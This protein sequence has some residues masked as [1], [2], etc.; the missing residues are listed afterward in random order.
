M[1]LR[2]HCGV[3]IA[4]MTDT[5][6][7]CLEQASSLISASRGCLF[8]LR[9]RFFVKRILDGQAWS[10][11]NQTAEPLAPGLGS[12]AEEIRPNLRSGS[13]SS[14]SVIARCLALELK[15]G[16]K[17]VLKAYRLCERIA[18]INDVSSV[19]ATLVKAINP[20]ARLPRPEGPDATC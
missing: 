14:F 18:R 19:S 1:F 10:A 7:V 13:S 20:F 6:G 12:G 3:L 2:K 15:L 9:R 16:C 8:D 5:I 11:R 4:T 17:I